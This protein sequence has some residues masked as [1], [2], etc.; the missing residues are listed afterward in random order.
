MESA[1]QKDLTFDEVAPDASA[2]IESMRAH[3]YTLSTA[4][5]DIID[6][7]ISAKCQNVW[8][9]FEWE[10][11]GPWISITDDGS[12]MSEDVLRNAMR[13]GSTNPLQVRDVGDLGRFGLGLKTAAFSQARRLTVASLVRGGKLALRRWDLDHLARPDVK[14]WQLLKSAHPDTKSRAEDVAARG[15]EGGTVV[16]LEN[17]DR[18]VPAEFNESD[19]VS[20]KHWVTE[21]ARVRAHL[22]MV[23]HRFLADSS[24]QGIKIFLNNSP[25]EPWDP[26]CTSE[27][28]TQSEAED[29]NHDL[30]MK[31]GV[32]GFVL[33]H[34]DR[35][36]T[37]DNIRSKK[38]HQ[39]AAGP[40]G[41]NAQQGFYLYRNRRLIIPGDWLGLGPGQNGW[42]K[43][44]HY[45]LA[46]VR[47]DIPNSMDL[48]WQIDVKKSSAIAPPALRGWLTGL[49]K[50]VREKAKEVYAH[51]GGPRPRAKGQ[52]IDHGRAWNTKTKLDGTFS[53]RVTRKHPLYQAL[54][55]VLKGDHCDRMETFLRLVEETVPV[56]RIWIDAAEHE[57]AFAKPFDGEKDD[58]LRRHIE[59]CHGALCSTGND[60]NSAWRVVSE[61]PAFQTE[62]AAAIIGQLREVAEESNKTNNSNL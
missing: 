61:F 26:F 25:V 31:I 50:T 39:E 7:S 60:K 14:G 15:L 48:E 51:R 55:S 19:T 58:K 24:R 13:L 38:L 17:L 34:R 3:G 22:A 1:L 42:K 37:S 6:N 11:G 53:Y 57:E 4:I 59:T 9:K 12:G 8:L 29:F 46:R 23:F 44:E 32:K 54:L 5:A 52:R 41:W 45:K 28:A 16:L 43:E 62:K 30:G 18:I 36:D 40:A 49:A 56:Q 20:E 10:H 27:D 33:P 2:M 21:V 35:F 47:V